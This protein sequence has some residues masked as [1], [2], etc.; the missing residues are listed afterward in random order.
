M[1]RG[2]MHAWGSSLAL[3]VVAAALLLALSASAYDDAPQC[4][5]HVYPLDGS[6]LKPVRE[7]VLVCWSFLLERGRA[8]AS[9]VDDDA[10]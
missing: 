3:F 9:N 10:I 8:F 5:S 4:E 2:R 7:R 1:R 6:T